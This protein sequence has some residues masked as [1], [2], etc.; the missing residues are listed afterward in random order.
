MFM[1]SLGNIRTNKFDEIYLS[2]KTNQIRESI[3]KNEC[4]KCW[5]NCYS[6]H[7]IMQNQSN[8]FTKL[9]FKFINYLIPLIYKFQTHC[10]F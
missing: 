7:S 10:N 8:Q 2:S 4:P 1:N 5:M 6:P 3:K 9:Y